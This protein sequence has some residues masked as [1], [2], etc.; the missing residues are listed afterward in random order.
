MSNRE[1][2][3]LT[4]THHN[5]ATE[6]ADGGVMNVEGMSTVTVFIERAGAGSAS[7]VKFWGSRTAA[8]T[9]PIALPGVKVSANMDVAVSTTGTGEAWMLDVSGFKYLMCELDAI[10]GVGATVTVVSYAK[11]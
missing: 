11:E 9:T 10:G 4:F 1:P 8:F 2:Y 5:A 6:A 7:T 3:L